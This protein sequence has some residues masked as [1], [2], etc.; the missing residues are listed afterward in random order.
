MKHLVI[1]VYEDVEVVGVFDNMEEV[2]K[3]IRQM[4]KD[5]D[6]ECRCIR[7]DFEDESRKLEIIR[8]VEEV[9][10]CHLTIC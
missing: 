6:G 1:D 8:S 7:I 3:A 10:Q 9:Y 2:K 4:I 5:T